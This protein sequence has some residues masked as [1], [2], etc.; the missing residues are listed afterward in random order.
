[1]LTDQTTYIAES[2]LELACIDESLAAHRTTGSAWVIRNI[3][4]LASLVKNTVAA[5]MREQGLAARRKK[6]RRGRNALRLRRDVSRRED[7][8]SL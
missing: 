5:L 6:R 3:K 1:M 4:G 2:V 7:S 8:S